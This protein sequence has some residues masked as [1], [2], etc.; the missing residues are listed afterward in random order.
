MAR[1]RWQNDDNSSSQR[2]EREASCSALLRERSRRLDLPRL[3]NLF[4]FQ[5]DVRLFRRLGETKSSLHGRSESRSQ[6]NQPKSWKRTAQWSPSFT[7]KAPEETRV[8][9]WTSRLSS[10]LITWT[11]LHG[12]SS[13]LISM[14]VLVFNHK[15]YVVWKQ[16]QLWFTCCRESVKHF[17]DRYFDVNLFFWQNG[18]QATE[19]W[20]MPCWRNLT[21]NVV[22]LHVQRMTNSTLHRGQY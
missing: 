16:P 20:L 18:T 7:V 19:D 9:T 11:S 10:T 8:V 22:L 14:C 3:C 17:R 4:K 1:W 2:S 21:F 5:I 13:A 6:L 15:N 12:K